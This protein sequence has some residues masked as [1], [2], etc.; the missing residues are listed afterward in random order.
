[1][2]VMTGWI[3]LNPNSAYCFVLALTGIDELILDSLLVFRE[4][5]YNLGLAFTR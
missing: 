5:M 4:G 1:M 3:F 2:K